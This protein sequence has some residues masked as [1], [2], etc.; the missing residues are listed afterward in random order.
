M[1]KA[2]EARD[3][4]A[5]TSSIVEEILET[6]PLDRGDF[7]AQGLE[8]GHRTLLQA[9]IFSMFQRQVGKHALQWQKPAVKTFGDA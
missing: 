8:Q 7:R 1:R 3:H 2:A 9:F 6:G 5:V 4:L